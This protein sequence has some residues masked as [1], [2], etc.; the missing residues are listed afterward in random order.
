VLV[1]KFNENVA[2]VVEM[3]GAGFF[4]SFVN[5]LVE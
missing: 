2:V 3:S 4:G 5:K 1:Q